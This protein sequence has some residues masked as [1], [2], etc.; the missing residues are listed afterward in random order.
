LDK[1]LLDREVTSLRGKTAEQAVLIAELRTTLEQHEAAL[2]KFPTVGR[3]LE[4]VETGAAAS[5]AGERRVR[6]QAGLR[7]R[8][9]AVARARKRLRDENA[10]IQQELEGLRQVVSQQSEFE[11]RISRL[12]SENERA[13]EEMAQLRQILDTA[14]GRQKE[15]RAMLLE[16]H[17]Q[18]LRRDEE[19]KAAQ[20]VLQ[21]TEEERE[22]TAAFRQAVLDRL[23]VSRTAPDPDRLC[24]AVLDLP[25]PGLQ[26]DLYQ[27]VVAG[28]VL[29]KSGPPEAVELIHDGQVLRR[30]LVNRLRQDVADTHP[31]VPISPASRSR[32]GC[33]SSPKPVR[34]RWP[35]PSKTG[36]AFAWRSFARDRTGSPRHRRAS[37][38]ARP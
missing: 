11:L 31:T 37:P 17:D 30:A 3:R 20:R 7:R 33:W 34:S 38:T 29:E 15:L 14:L 27:I 21:Q 4:E 22:E 9:R 26:T 18:L 5:A 24:G 1:E 19:L 10:T 16:A 6:V 8:L 32:C 13:A 23:E 28:W 12:Q 2:K 35:S 36:A 25:A